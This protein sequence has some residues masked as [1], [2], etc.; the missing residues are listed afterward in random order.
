MIIMINGAFGVGKTTI[1]SWLQ[2]SLANSMIY[3]P[4]EV[5]Y[6]LR[7]LIPSELKAPEE[8]TDNF[9][10][11]EL[12]K[13]LVVQVAEQLHKKYKKT[14]LVPM[15]ICNKDY[16]HYIFNGLKQ[17]D[18]ETYH[19]CLIGSQ[20]TIFERLRMRGEVEGNW[21]FQ[22]TLKCVEAYQDPCFQTYIPTDGREIDDIVNTIKARIDTSSTGGTTTSQPG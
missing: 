11:M 6:M 3:D 21:C 7:N 13:I 5:G 20:E 10:D 14:I 18:A 12:W 4:E 19:F 22:Q 8:Q 16:F 15:T 2:A 1:A 17:I 9:Q